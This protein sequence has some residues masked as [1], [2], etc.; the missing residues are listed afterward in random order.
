MGKLL[1][2]GLI[3][4]IFLIPPTR[5]YAWVDW[6]HAA[7]ID[8]ALRAR[9]VKSFFDRANLPVGLPWVRE[10]E[11]A[12]NAAKAVIV[13]IGPHGLG[14]TQQYERDLALYRQTR[15]PSFP[16]VPVIL[17]GA[18]IER[19]FNFL[20]ILTWID[21]SRVSKVSDAPPIRCGG[22]AIGQREVFARLRRSSTGAAAR[23]RS[24][25]ECPDLAARARATA[26]PSGR[27]PIAG[28]KIYCCLQA[29][30]S[31]APAL[32]WPTAVTSRST[33]LASLLK[34]AKPRTKRARRR[35]GA[36]ACTSGG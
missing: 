2:M 23:A 34:K 25:L 35:F 29:F 28:V 30:S 11:K 5:S 24:V 15:D 7:D 16:I 6:R 32:C 21:L 4:R 20:Q 31:N 10:L 33:I 26:R 19:P 36:R 13:L 14:N 17:P 9:G 1:R 3:L 8:S 22:R 18:E 27:L 12:L